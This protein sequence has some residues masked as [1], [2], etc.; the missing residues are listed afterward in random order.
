MDARKRV[1]KHQPRSEVMTASGGNPRADALVLCDARRGGVE[2]ETHALHSLLVAG[3][4]HA[5]EPAP[6]PLLLRSLFPLLPPTRERLPIQRRLGI[7][8]PLTDGDHAL[9]QRDGFLQL[10]VIVLVAR[11]TRSHV[12]FIPSRP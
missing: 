5:V 9:H 2:G 12:R 1:E 3:H 7:A 11:Q 8:E 6:V 10:A 4:V